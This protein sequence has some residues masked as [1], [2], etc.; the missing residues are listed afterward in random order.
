M[1]VAAIRIVLPGAEVP[2]H[3]HRA[4]RRSCG[5][6]ARSPSAPCGPA[7]CGRSA[8]SCSAGGRARGPPRRRASAGRTGPRTTS[9]PRPSRPACRSRSRSTPSPGRVPNG[10]AARSGASHACSA[11]RPTPEDMLRIASRRE[12]AAPVMPRST[13]YWPRSPASTGHRWPLPLLRGRPRVAVARAGRRSRRRCSGRSRR[14]CRCSGGSCASTIGERADDVGIVVG[15][16]AEPRVLE[17]AGV[18]HACAG[19]ASGRRCRRRS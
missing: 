5:R 3:R 2:R 11:M 14:R 19:R 15:E 7:C 8:W 6:S 16:Q 17:E 10:E 9:A 4:R 12:S 13:S 1:L 18:D